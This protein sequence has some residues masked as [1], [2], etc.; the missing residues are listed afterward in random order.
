MTG[1]TIEGGACG[2]DIDEVKP[3]TLFRHLAGMQG[4]SAEILKHT[5]PAAI[6]SK[7]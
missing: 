5:S 3:N 4:S 1:F 2:L 7:A 6:N